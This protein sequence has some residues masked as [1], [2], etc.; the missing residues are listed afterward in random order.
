MIFSTVSGLRTDW[1][2]ALVA[3]NKKAYN[4]CNGFIN[5]D[6]FLDNIIEKTFFTSLIYINETDYNKTYTPG[7]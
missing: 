3:N 4:N 5:D 6:L 2:K 7:G 1:P